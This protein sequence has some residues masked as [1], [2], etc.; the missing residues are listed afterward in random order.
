ML[1]PTWKWLVSFLPFGELSALWPAAS[2]LYL[3][4]QHLPGQM[5]SLTSKNNVLV[6][7]QAKE[8]KKKS[9]S[10]SHPFGQMCEWHSVFGYIE[11]L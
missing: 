3:L 9:M 8:R 11:H 7:V 1:W 6:G 10:H 4:C 2:E 5:D